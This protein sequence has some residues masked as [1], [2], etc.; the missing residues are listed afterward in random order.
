MPF[1]GDPE[2]FRLAVESVR[3][4]T[5]PEWTLTILDDCYPDLEPGEWVQNLN[6][7]RI[8]YKRNAINLLPSGNYNQA[9]DLSSSEFIMLMGCDDLLMPNFVER[10]KKLISE[11]PLNVA[12][13]QPGVKTI[14]EYGQLHIGL[15]D[16]VKKFIGPWPTSGYSIVSGEEAHMGLLRGNWTYFPSIL[17]RVSSIGSS[18]FRTDLNVVQDLSMILNL[19]E[20][21]KAI[22]V[23]SEPSFCYRRHKQSFSGATGIDGSK[24][25]QESI[26]FK[27][28]QNRAIQRGWAKSAKAAKQHHLSRLN[29]LA[30]LPQALFTRNFKGIRNLLRHIFM[31]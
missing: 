15:A 10:S 6:D 21:G 25:A 8:T 9:I 22:L 30:E 29:A 19:I 1:Y 16:R 7:A 14:D 28:T 23:D 4:Q 17:W 27:E 26:L 20:S 2:H 31:S 11:A 18:R 3:A 24:F 13:I 5:D 12:I